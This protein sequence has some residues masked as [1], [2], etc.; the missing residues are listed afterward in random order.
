MVMAAKTK[1]DQALNTDFPLY[2]AIRPNVD[3]WIRIFTKVS[4]HQG[5][6]HDTKNLNLIY[7]TIRLDGSHTH[8]AR[9]KNRAIKKKAIKKY[10]SMLLKLA[11]G[12]TPSTREEKQTLALFGDETTPAGLNRSA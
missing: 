6:L 3:F 10:K 9:K 11:A 1:P 12:T 4:K 8:A 5:L 2:P 7:G